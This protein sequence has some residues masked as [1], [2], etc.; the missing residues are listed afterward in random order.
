MKRTDQLLIEHLRKNARET[1]TSISRK[2]KIPIS[3]LYDKLKLHEKSVIVKHATIVDFSKLGYNCRAN[4]FLKVERDLR[5]KL[6]GYLKAH[7]SVNN[8]FKVN[9]GFDFLVEGVFESVRRMEDFLEEIETAFKLEEK[10]AH[11][12]IEDLK[13][14]GFMSLEAGQRTFL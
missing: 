7:S 11:Y 13:R 9:N 1:L 8:L 10:K 12:I 5:E 14:E 3:T 4:I 2:T 6:C